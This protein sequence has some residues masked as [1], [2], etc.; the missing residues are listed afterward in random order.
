MILAA[1]NKVNS[2][3]RHDEER[4][5]DLPG[6]GSPSAHLYGSRCTIRFPGR[7]CFST[8]SKIRQSLRRGKEEAYTFIRFIFSADNSAF[9]W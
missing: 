3:S 4:L 8:N 6:S 1:T 5:T 7:Q 2:T 9:F